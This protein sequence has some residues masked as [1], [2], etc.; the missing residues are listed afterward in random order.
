MS[1]GKYLFIFCW[2]FN[3]FSLGVPQSF[4]PLMAWFSGICMGA[5]FFVPDDWHP[6]MLFDMKRNPAPPHQSD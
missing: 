4:K 1:A 3:L 5:S 6:F 2:I